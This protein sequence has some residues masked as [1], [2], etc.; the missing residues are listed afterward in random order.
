M[1]VPREVLWR[2][3]KSRGVHVAYIRAI[4]GMYD[5]AKTQIR[6]VGGDLEHNPI[7]M[8]LHQRCCLK[9]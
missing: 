8:G 9:P 4:K 1:I 5:G 7:M 2:C 6:T 3:L